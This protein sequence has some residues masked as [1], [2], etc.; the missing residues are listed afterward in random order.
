MRCRRFKALPFALPLMKDLPKVRTYGKPFESIGVDLCGYFKVK[1]QQEIVSS[2][3][4]VF[5]CLVT[6][7]VH[8]ELVMSL[9]GE[10][11]IDA[12]T[13]FASRRGMPSF[14]YSDNGTNLK[15]AS[16]TVIPQ[17]ISKAD[18]DVMD[19][20]ISKKIQWKFVTEKTPW[21]GGVYESMVKLVK[22][23]LKL[24]VGKKQI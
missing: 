7:A 16:L 9:S 1:L 4:V 12:L 24:A 23:N 19:Y 22:R 2:W 21:A 17:W 14:I 8:L 13:R 11:F 6:R 3:I 5:T 15:V 18:T 20:C 10:A